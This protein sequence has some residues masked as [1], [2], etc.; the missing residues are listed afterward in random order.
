MV[1]LLRR[2][3]ILT[4]LSCPACSSPL[5]R[6]RGGDLWCSQCQKQVI[7]VKEG[8]KETETAIPLIFSALEATLLTKIKEVDEKIKAEDNLE[9]LQRLSNMLSTLLENLERVRRMKNGS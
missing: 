4:Q 9:Q 1:D 7:I 8:E 5:F 6:L 3:A 2:G